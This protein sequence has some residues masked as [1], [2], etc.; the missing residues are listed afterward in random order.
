[1]RSRFLAAAGDRERLG[2]LL[3]EKGWTKSP[4]AGWQVALQIPDLLILATDDGPRLLFEDGAVLGTLFSR[5]SMARHGSASPALRDAIRRG[6]GQCLIDDHWGAWFAIFDEPSGHWALRD[7]S[8]FAPAYY[9]ARD[10]LTLYFSDL[11]TAL[12]L[13]IVEPEVDIAFLRH[14]L[15]YPHLRTSRTGLRAIS[16]LLPGVRRQVTRSRASAYSAWDPWRFAAPGQQILDFDDAATALRAMALRVIA[17]Q[18]CDRGRLLLELSGGLDSSIIAA[19]LDAGGLPFSTV[20]FTT[21]T[22]EGDERRYAA[23]VAEGRSEEHGEIAEGEAVLELSLPGQRRLRPGLSPVMAPL[24]RQFADFGQHLGADTF[25]TGAGGDNVFCFL[26]TAAPVLDAWRAIGP[27]E[28]LGRVVG[29]IS[30]MCG[31]TSWTTLRY[32]MRKAGREWRAPKLWRLDTDFLA[33]GATPSGPESHPWLEGFGRATPGKREHVT[34]LLRIQHVIDPETRLPGLYFLHPLVAQPMMELC[35]RIPTWLW[36]RDGRNRAVA[37]RAFQGLL[38][39]EVLA[40]RGKGGLEGLC[41]RAYDRHKL[42]L[43]DLLLGGSLREADLLDPNALEA[44]FEPS[45]PPPDARYFRIFELAAT[46]LW[47]RSWRR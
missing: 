6:S 22:A 39:D 32:A 36:V 9:R 2:A 44:Y 37:R 33:P 18:A 25:L 17:A 12:D 13:D 35:L 42:E 16:E 28:A 40:R 5:D 47:L 29:D 34:A 27:R 46:E 7:P 31:C 20:N 3:D 30:E 24:H 19:S 15:A 10:G 23:A 45:G 4:P 8:A 26:T 38:P 1:M 43:A 21:R 14:W 11:Q 41:Q